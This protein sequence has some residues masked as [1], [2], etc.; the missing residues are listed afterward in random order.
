MPIQRVIK[1]ILA[2]MDRG[3]AEVSPEGLERLVEAV[4][5]ADHI[6][7]AGGGRSGLMARA[8]AMRLMH[9]GLRTYVVGETT[10]PAIHS[11]DLLVSCSASG[12]TQVTVLVSHVAQKAGARVFA[13]TATPDSPM[14]R[15]SDETIVIPAPSK[16]SAPSTALSAQYG[17]SL[18][19]QA[20]LVLLDAVSS[21]IGRR[22]GTPHQE[23][24]SRHANLE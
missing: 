12:E 14:A 10:T 4:L 13:I 2:E 16:R 8:F 6:Y 22:L 5:K 9:L 23:L 21:E 3:L 15:L 19:E 17:G 18:F 24:N 11:G 1:E 7:V 20:L